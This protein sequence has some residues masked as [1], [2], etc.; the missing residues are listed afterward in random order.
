M[1]DSKAIDWI[2]NR[3]VVR[4]GAAWAAK[5]A[6]V[7]DAD[8]RADWGNELARVSRYAILYALGYLPETFPPTVVEFRAICLRAPPPPTVRLDAP[9]ADPARARAE[10]AKMKTL[11]SLRKPLQW[12]YDLQER[13]SQGGSL[14]QGQRDAYKAALSESCDT[15]IGGVFTP[16]ADHLLPPG[17]RADAHC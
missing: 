10:L 17:M 9:K 3:M 8:V 12:A 6:G 2:F 14:T 7:N 5:W 1:L 11:A 4:Y 15:A 13:D 16:I